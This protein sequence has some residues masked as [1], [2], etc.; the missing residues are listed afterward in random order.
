MDRTDQDREDMQH[1][2]HRREQII[3]EAVRVADCVIMD[4]SDGSNEET[5][6]LTA[7]VAKAFLEK[8]LQPF[9]SEMLRKD[10][11]L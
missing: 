1:S 2:Q 11:K 9:H 4:G 7:L 6:F 10:L 5:N 8:A 3:R